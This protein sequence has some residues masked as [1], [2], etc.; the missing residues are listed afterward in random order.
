MKKKIA[1]VFALLFVG[2][3]IF[4]TTQI[5]KNPKRYQAKSVLAKELNL[6]TEQE[7]TMVDIFDQCGIG[8]IISAIQFQIGDDHTSYWL[9][10][11]ETKAYGD[12][13]VVW[14]TN[15]TK[16][17][18]SVYYGNY[19]IFVDNQVVGQVTDYYVNS[20][21]RDKYRTSSQMLINETLNFPDTADYPT[22]SEWRY[23]IEDGLV[24][25]QSSVTA[26]NAFGVPST[27]DFQVKWQ[28]GNPVSLI[29]D[30]HEYLS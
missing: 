14:V 11:N 21:D 5:V 7:S 17:L 27:L 19:D 13:I 12:A 28:N 16:A 1:I 22:S 25:V 18:E 30:G 10:D 6:T 23:G 26:Q 29:V 9:H 24:I 8:E 2:A 3:L 20:E 4:G 15:S